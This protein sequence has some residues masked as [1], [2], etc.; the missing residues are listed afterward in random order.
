MKTKAYVLGRCP[1]EACPSLNGDGEGM[2]GGEIDW[3][4]ESR[5]EV[6]VGGETAI[7]M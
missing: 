3:R 2:D 5:G 6:C 4:Q 7:G 1:R